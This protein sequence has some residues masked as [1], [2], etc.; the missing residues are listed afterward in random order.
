MSPMF[1]VKQ[2][3][4]EDIPFGIFCYT[5]FLQLNAQNLHIFKKQ[6]TNFNG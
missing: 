6:L 2:M 3:K 1:F 4:R 5:D